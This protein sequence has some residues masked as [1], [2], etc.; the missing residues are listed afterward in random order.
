MAT[1][2]NDL[3]LKEIATGDEEGTWGASTNTN[4]E[5]I[6]EAFSYGTLAISGSQNLTITDG[7][8]AVARSLFIKI[9]GTLSGNA[10]L[11]I[12]PNTVSKVWAIQNATSGGYS[13]IISQGSGTNVTI[14][15]SRT[16]ILYSDGGGSSANIVEVTSALDLASFTAGST[17]LISSILDEDNMA[18]NSA[19]ALATQQSIKAYV[20]T[21][22]TAEDLDFA[23][24]S[25]S[26]SVDLD[27]QTFTIAGTS[28]E[29][30]TSAS[31]QTLTIGLPDDVTIGDDLTLGSDGAVLGF[32]AGTDVTLTHVHD[33]GLLLNGTMQLQFNDASQN[34]TAPSATVLDINATDEI[35]L[36]ATAVD[37]NGTLDVSGAATLATSLNIASDGATVT[38]IKDEDDMA[39]NSAVKLATQQSIKAYVD[40]QITAED[41]DFAG[42]SGSGSVDL[43]SQTFTIAG[44]SNEVETSGSGQ[45][46]TV[47]LPSNVTIGNN[48]T[49]TNDLDVDGTTN[50][51]AVDVDG[52]VQIDSTVTVGVNDTGY[53]VKF[54]GATSGAYMLWDESADDLV[55]A[56][57]AKLG[58]GTTSP[59]ELLDVASTSTDKGIQVSCYST[60][61]G[62]AGTIRLAHSLSGTIGSHTAVTVNDQLGRIFFAGSDG[63]DFYSGA[64]IIADSTQNFTAS[65]GGTR[66][67]FWT[68]PTNTQSIARAMTIEQDGSVGIGIASPEALLHVYS[69]TDIPM[70]STGDGQIKIGG[71][72]Y[73]GAIALDGSNMNIYHNSSSRGLVLGTNETARLTIAG[74]GDVTIAE[75]LFCSSNVGIGTTSPGR[76]L[77]LKESS[78][79]AGDAVIRL[80][81]NGNNAD[82]TVLGALEWYNADSSGDQPGVVCRIEGVSGNANGHMGEIVFQTHDGTEGGEGSNPVERMRI[83]NSGD[84]GI[85]TASPSE[86]LD[87]VGNLTVSGS[88]SKGSGSF[89]IDHPLP[90]MSDTHHLVHSFVEGPKADLIYRGSVSLVGGAATVDLD[91]AAT[92]TSGTWEVLCRDPQVWVQNEDGWTQVRGSISGTTLSIEAQDATCTDTVSWLVV[93]ER[94]DP[95]IVSANWTDAEG[96]VIVEPLK[97]IET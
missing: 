63:T 57:A 92:M 16:K 91:A 90:A 79:A 81:G 36:N 72:A 52:A 78:T 9:T 87:V 95:N 77:E 70:S 62:S 18:S 31:G 74:G 50:L 21:Q 48:L 80:R 2:V 20:D 38:G 94:K 49:V 56:G 61:Q 59:E 42:D 45:T 54:F 73:K 8:S 10:T 43:D 17:T 19:T 97:N 51:D 82:N 7:G 14:P 27:S 60:T 58:V 64:A 37:L 12:D 24:D 13:L 6:G 65:N 93:A 75:D 86:K 23:G 25:G 69:G 3:R 30:E 71:N 4:L 28:N 33:T 68:T 89:K 85:G 41:L 84:V 44:T 67:E 15:A 34:I 1:Y 5:L 11:T 32:G 76:M 55:L 96:R 88:V 35:E 46:L 83:D 39:S 26:G 40:A 47:G 29:I 22:L 53:D 66:L